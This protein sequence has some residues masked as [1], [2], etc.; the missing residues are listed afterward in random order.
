LHLTGGGDT[1]Y[2]TVISI[3]DL[4]TLVVDTSEDVFTNNPG[5]PFAVTTSQI[6]A[7]PDG[8]IADVSGL[9]GTL[10]SAAGGF[11][12]AV[13]A[14][15][16]VIIEDAG[17]PGHNGTYK[18]ITV[19]SDTQLTIDTTDLIFT[20]QTALDFRVVE[21]GMYLQYKKVA[22]TNN[23]TT[24]YS[25]AAIA[26]TITRATGT[27]AASVGPGTIIEVA[28]AGIAANNGKYTVLS[29]DSGV[30]ITLVDSDVLVDSSNDAAAAI[31]VSEG[32]K[33]DVG[34]TIYAYNWRLFGNGAESSDCYQFVQHQLRQ[35]TDID[36]GEGS[37]RGDITDLLLNY[38]A[39]TGVG[40]NLVIDDLNAAN[41]NDTSYI[42]HSGASRSFPF[43]AAGQILFNNNLAGDADAKYWLFFSNDD[44]GDNIGRDYSTDNAIVVK[45]GNGVDIQGD[46]TGQTSISF[47][48]DY[49]GNVQRGAASAGVNA[50]VTLVAIGLNSAQFV[51]VQ[52]TINR[53]TAVSISAVA[54]LERNYIP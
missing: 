27:W 45:D 39:P 32:F 5:V 30:Q 13:E 46:L 42:D 1:G 22:V 34:G 26:K 41:I 20:T 33:R 23:S 21:P 4:N 35:T 24:D 40:L 9:T 53:S 31:T 49:D 6:L 52:G 8:A 15:D 48:Y 18:V 28:S 19:D 51:V 36:F 37:S 11:T 29:R 10:S 25:F 14:N 16:L 44:A 17:T 7:G 12:A 2:Y 54:A 3:T 38:S 50:P 47:T 43:S